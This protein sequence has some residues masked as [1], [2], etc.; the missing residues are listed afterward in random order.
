M[1]VAW[2]ALVLAFVAA[3]LAG[4]ALGFALQATARSREAALRIEEVLVTLALGDNPAAS[5]AKEPTDD[6]LSD[7]LEISDAYRSRRR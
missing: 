1:T 4:V 7:M 2:I 3:A 6:P 5:E